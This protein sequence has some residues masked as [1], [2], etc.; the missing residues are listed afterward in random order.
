[1]LHEATLQIVNGFREEFNDEMA[2]ESAQA[3]MG[4]E[5]SKL[6]PCPFAQLRQ[7]K[8]PKTTIK[9]VFGQPILLQIII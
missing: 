5:N 7:S 2:G 1:M 3:A 4:T 8:I 9:D 6:V